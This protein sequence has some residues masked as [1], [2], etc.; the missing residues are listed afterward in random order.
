VLTGVSAA[1]QRPQIGIVPATFDLIDDY[2]GA[3]ELA[4]GEPVVIRRSRSGHRQLLEMDA[5]LLTSV[6]VLGGYDL[7]ERFWTDAPEDDYWWND[8]DPEGYLFE[9][10]EWLWDVVRWAWTR[11]L[12]T[13]G[14]GLGAQLIAIEAGASMERHVTGHERKHPYMPEGGVSQRLRIEPGSWLDAVRH[15]PDPDEMVVPGSLD[16][17]PEIKC[18]HHQGIKIPSRPRKPSMGTLQVVAWT[19]DDMPHAWARCDKQGVPRQFGTLWEPQ[20]EE[21]AGLGAGLF[22][23]FIRQLGR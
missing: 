22:T 23:W 11:K 5:L 3:V 21:D 4:G 2:A 6:G 7:P 12:P 16:S 13:L 8:N 9:Q 18:S 15:T 1:N 10:C 19:E 14:A 20:H 17:D